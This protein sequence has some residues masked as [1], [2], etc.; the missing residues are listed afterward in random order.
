MNYFKKKI[1]ESKARMVFNTNVQTVKDDDPYYSVKII[2]VASGFLGVLYAS[3]KEARKVLI[4][5]D[6]KIFENKKKIGN[7]KV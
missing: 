3:G 7:F 2:P 1:D 5:H 6:G 4:R